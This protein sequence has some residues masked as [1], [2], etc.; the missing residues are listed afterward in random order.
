MSAHAFT[1]DRF[2]FH[3]LKKGTNGFDVTYLAE[4]SLGQRAQSFFE[5]LFEQQLSGVRY[6]FDQ[7]DGAPEPPVKGQARDLLEDRIDF[8]EAS[9]A[10]TR[11]FADR[12]AAQATD[13]VFIIAAATL[14]ARPV[15]VL[16]KYDHIEAVE[17]LAQDGTPSVRYTE[18]VLTLDKDN[19]MKFAL[20]DPDGTDG[21]DVIA[22][23]LQTRPIAEY[24]R[25]FLGVRPLRTAQEQTKAAIQT[26]KR[27]AAGTDTL[28]DDILPVDVQYRAV[29]YMR[30][31]NTYSMEP[32]LERLLGRETDGNRS[33]RAALRKDLSEAELDTDFGVDTGAV[34]AA[35]EK[36]TMQT[37]E[38]V[39]IVMPHGA[40]QGNV[41]VET[42]NGRRRIII[43]T[44]A[45]TTLG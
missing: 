42:I 3:I 38:G 40:E 6:L 41:T 45:I 32:F 24:F 33:A 9:K 20:I 18:D 11:D 7:P 34:S 37:R 12:H 25:A 4:T 31:E 5:A 1:I 2:V 17:L 8:L 27:W 16:M 13:G 10:L 39:R 15:L 28:P 35:M 19:V 26:V 29:D 14:G 44:D 30:Q 23:D 43:E 22:T 21:W 36:Q